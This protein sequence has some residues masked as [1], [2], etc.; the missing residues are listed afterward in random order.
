MGRIDF[1]TGTALE[2]GCELDEVADAPIDV[3][4]SRKINK[5]TELQRQS[6]KPARPQHHSAAGADGPVS[7]QDG[8]LSKCSSSMRPSRYLSQRRGR[9]PEDSED[10][11]DSTVAVHWWQISVMLLEETSLPLLRHMASTNTFLLRR[12][13]ASTT[14]TLGPDVERK[15]LLRN[16]LRRKWHTVTTLQ[17]ASVDTTPHMTCFRG[18]KVCTKWLQGKSDD[19][20]IQLDNKMRIW[21]RS[22]KFKK[23]ENAELSMAW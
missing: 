11:G 15:T 13:S 5:N 2:P 9:T 19:E 12:G 22:G 16:K 23:V 3:S 18:A 21:T 20:L 1:V 8:R 10:H 17:E 14:G 7:I 4:G 6:S